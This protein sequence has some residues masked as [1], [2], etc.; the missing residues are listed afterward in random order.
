MNKNLEKQLVPGAK[1]KIGKEYERLHSGC[2]SCIIPCKNKLIHKNVIELVTGRFDHENGLFTETL[3][4]PA[5]WCE[6][7][8]DYESIFHLFGNDLEDFKDCNILDRK[9]KYYGHISF[10]ILEGFTSLSQEME[11]EDLKLRL[12]HA[13]DK[14]GLKDPNISINTMEIGDTQENE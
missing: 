14:I 2:S 1:I 11:I 5:I 6:E 10:N 12:A 7:A 8:K 4:S 3:E 13:L 9:T